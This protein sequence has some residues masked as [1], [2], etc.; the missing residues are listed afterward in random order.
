M[1]CA[2][3]GMMCF[4]GCGDSSSDDSSSASDTAS[5]AAESSEAEETSEE[6]S[7]ETE[8]E[9]ASDDL[10]APVSDTTIDVE[11]DGATEN[12]LIRSIMSEGDSTRIAE[13]L[14]AAI[15]LVNDDSMEATEKVAYAT[16]VAFIG[17]SITAGSVTTSN[18]NTYVKQFESWWIDNIGYYIET[19][20]AGIGATDSYLGVHRVDSEVLAEN[21]DIIFI[22]FINDT[23]DDFYKT[24]M[25][26]LIRK[27]LAQEN[28]PAVILVEMTTESGSSAQEVHAEIAEYYGVPVI[29]YH[30]AVMPEVEAGTLDY[31]SIQN[32]E[33]HPNDTGHILL[34]QL[35]TNYIQTIIDDLDNLDKVSE[36]F[37]TSLESPTGDKYADA[38]LCDS[39]SELVTVVDEGT[40]TEDTTVLWNFADGWATSTEGTIEFEMEFKNLGILYTE[41]YS[42]LGGIA[43]ISI[44]GEEVTTI[45]ADFTSGWGDYACNV[46]LAAYDEKATHTVTVT[47]AEG[48][49]TNFEILRWMIS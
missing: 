46:E 20:N 33:V 25:D 45:D 28:N 37:D 15:D 2:A 4:A 5:S 43:T 21:P 14:Q 31:D 7:S 44:D 11:A 24:T 32:D 39:T 34:G 17:D 3:L 40:F 9:E 41:M 48:T 8:S 6:D 18:D 35:L 49:G 13:K 30:D 10:K 16:K 22:E 36:A 27:C 26:S 12:M 47:V 23:N 29:S 38:V 1:L 42:T 19:I